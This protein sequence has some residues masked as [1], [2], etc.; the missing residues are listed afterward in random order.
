[1][2]FIEKAIYIL[3]PTL[4]VSATEW[5]ELWKENQRNDFVRSARLILVLIALVYIGHY[6]FFDKVLGLTPIEHWFKFRFG[7]ASLCMLT[8]GFYSI[9]KL[10]QKPWYKIPMMIALAAVCITQAHVSVWYQPASYLFSCTFTYLSAVLL[11]T[12]ILKSLAYAGILTMRFD[13]KLQPC[14]SGNLHFST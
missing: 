10:S 9:E 4:L 11:R 1:M 14:S 5:Y 13:F 7:M 8:F 12:S 2:R 3:F 6:F